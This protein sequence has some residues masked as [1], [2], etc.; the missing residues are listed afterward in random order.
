MTDWS[1]LDAAMAKADALT[2]ARHD[3]RGNKKGGWSEEAREAA[4]SKRSGGG[5]Q[6]HRPN[7]KEADRGNFMR[8]VYTLI[9]DLRGSP[10]DYDE[11]RQALAGFENGKTPERVA[12]AIIAEHGKSPTEYG[13]KP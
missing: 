9:E 2:A 7:Q 5:S 3:G 4:S 8:A 6:Y 10:P 12:K 11:R 13:E 1:K